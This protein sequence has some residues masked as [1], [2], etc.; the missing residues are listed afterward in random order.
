MIATAITT[1]VV[2]QRM[3]QPVGLPASP[4]P[5]L[6]VVGREVLAAV[7]RAPAPPA[8]RAVHVAAQQRGPLPLMLP[9]Q[10]T[11]GGAEP[12][13]RDHGQVHPLALVRPGSPPREPGLT[14]QL[15]RERGAL[16]GCGDTWSHCA[17]W[18]HACPSEATQGDQRRSQGG[19]SGQESNLH[20][21]AALA[22]RWAPTACIGRLPG[23]GRQL[24]ELLQRLAE[25]VILPV[26][27]GL[28]ERDRGRRR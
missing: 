6:G 26:R 8:R 27:A 3:Q 22:I 23:S 21:R 7:H 13:D 20:R 17:R 25:I 24:A 15:P 28:G 19:D 5:S 18:L 2:T 9:A 12:R 14:V 1:R 4:C 11:L 16:P 10:A